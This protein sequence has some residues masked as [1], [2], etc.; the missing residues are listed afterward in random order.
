MPS[1]GVLVDRLPPLTLDERRIANREVLREVPTAIG[2]RARP[3]LSRARADVRARATEVSA[4]VCARAS[5]N[6]VAL[7]MRNNAVRETERRAS[8]TRGCI[9]VERVE[10]AS[11]YVVTSVDEML[12]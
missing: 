1:D 4:P 12:E 7:A 2:E 5:P 9:A 8:G 6:A 3:I 10:E 11:R